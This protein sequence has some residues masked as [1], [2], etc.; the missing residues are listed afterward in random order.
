VT[1][2]DLMEGADH[3]LDSHVYYFDVGSGAW[4][5]RF[6][7]R[8][9]DFRTFRGASLGVLNR[10]LA[11]SMH[12]LIRIGGWCTISSVVTPHPELGPDGVADNAVRISKLGVTLYTLRERYT[13]DRDG[14]NV[15]VRA[16]ERFGPIPFL[17]NRRKAHPAEVSPGGLRAVYHIPLLGDEWVGTYEVAKGRNHIDSTLTCGW[18][19]ATE[20]IDRV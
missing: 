20:V 2:N 19:R 6:E 4:R 7:F 3:R 15:A 11:L 5:G 17:L 13:L 9:T 10:L 1:A 14:T 12:W 18:G 8:L 16:Q